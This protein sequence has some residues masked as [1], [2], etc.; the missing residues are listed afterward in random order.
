L[1]QKQ[2]ADL[3]ALA[4]MPD[5]RIDY[6]DLPSAE[7]HEGRAVRGPFYKPIKQQITTRVDADVLDW[8]KSQG[9]G[10]QARMNAIRR[11]ASYDCRTMVA[12]YISKRHRGYDPRRR[13]GDGAKAVGTKRLALNQKKSKMRK[14]VGLDL[15]CR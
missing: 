5:D 9:E 14:A 15:A 12:A 4:Q 3:H 7:F 6:S 1:T 11:I 8:L 2:R 10:Y 13:L